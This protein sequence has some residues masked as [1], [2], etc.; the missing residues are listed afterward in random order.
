MPTI[1][2]D[3]K[4]INK[5]IGKDLS[6]EELSSILEYLKCEI[7]EGNEEEII[8]EI[9]TDRADCF[10]TEGI[11]RAMKGIMGIE[12]GPVN[13]EYFEDEIEVHVHENVEKIRPYVA[14][15]TVRGVKL[16]PRALESII[17][18]QEILH[19]SLGRDRKKASIGLYDLS[20]LDKKIFFKC[21]DLSEIKFKP[22]EREEIL[23]GYRILSETEKGKQ[24]RYLVGKDHAPVLIDSKGTY[25]S[26]APIINSQDAK[27]TVKTTDIL[28]DST[29]FDLNFISSIVALMAYAITF[30]GGKIGF[31]KHYYPNSSFILRFKERYLDIEKDWVESILGFK[32]SEE[33]FQE[34]LLRARYGFEKFDSKYKIKVP[35]YRIDVLGEIDIAEDIAIMKGYENIE[36]KSPILETKAK[37]SEKS[38]L[39]TIVREI[40]NGLGFQEVVNY[41]I[42]NSILQ[43]ERVN[44]N[45]NEIGLIYIT[46]PISREYDCIRANLFPGILE[47]LY[48][49]RNYSYPQKIYE[50]GDVLNY[51]NNK[52]NT[53][54]RLSAAII[55]NSASFEDMHSCIYS[56]LN[57]IGLSFKLIE[58]N[59]PFL[60]QGR[61]AN[62][63]VNGEIIGWL[64]ELNPIISERF[65]LYQPIVISEIS[66]SKIIK[67]KFS[68]L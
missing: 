17:R 35:F 60:L 14:M 51:Q 21:L 68:K 62:I 41:M 36:L 61:R 47:F 1:I 13:I 5:A 42:T 16:D 49:N 44:L 29:G 12:K 24:Y 57:S 34:S 63:L 2:L 40:F 33:E 8:C 23:D 25:L 53:D 37:L 39:S 26:M 55:Y 66:L 6:L 22:L 11:I 43:T 38:K 59:L 19:A 7:K 3:R 50:I 18:F 58:N 32:I 64:G 15:A 65:S 31:V 67:F 56:F 52:I 28:I 30:Y 20:K 45:P 27:V 9:T 54:F 10:S 4:R 48:Y 46:N